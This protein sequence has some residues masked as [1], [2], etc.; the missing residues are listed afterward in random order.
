MIS[1]YELR[2]GNVTDVVTG[3]PSLATEEGQMFAIGPNDLS[4][5][6]RGNLFFTIGFGGNPTAREDLFGPD[7]AKLAHLGRATPNGSWR[8]LERS[9]PVRSRSQSDGR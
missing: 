6:G 7:G 8:L 2:S 9:R 5:Q 4:L 3:L 1:R